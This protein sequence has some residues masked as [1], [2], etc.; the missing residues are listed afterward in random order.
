MRTTRLLALSLGVATTL[1]A[2]GCRIPP[3]GVIQ[4]GEP[5]NGLRAFVTL[6]WVD[7][8]SAEHGGLH[9]VSRPADEVTGVAAAVSTLVAGPTESEWQSGLATQLPT[10]MPAPRVTVTGSAVTIRLQPG[11]PRLTGTAI[12]QLACTAT[13]AWQSSGQADDGAD[14]RV[15]VTS[16]PDTDPGAGTEAG[17]AARAKSSGWQVRRDGADCPSRPTPSRADPAATPPAGEVGG[18]EIGGGV[19]GGGGGV[20]PTAAPSG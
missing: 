8:G 10:P 2:S 20:P 15:T 3:S 19:A 11:F 5:A 1:L 7:R 9:P 17:P 16:P 18:G 13:A 14:V 12:G 6:Y 4:A